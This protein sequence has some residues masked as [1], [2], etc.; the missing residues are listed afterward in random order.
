MSA[1]RR[2][3]VVLSFD[4]DGYAPWVSSPETCDPF[5]VSRG[6]FVP[7]A[8]RRLLCLL[9]EKDITATFFVPGHTVLTFPDVVAAAHAGGHEIGHHGWLHHPP[10]QR[11]PS[12]EADDLHRGLDAIMS[13]T[14]ER[15]ESYRA[16][17]FAP[18]L[19]TFRL[20]REFDF[21]CD[22]SLMGSDIDPYRLRVCDAWSGDAPYE[23]GPPSDIVELPVAN[24][25]D[26]FAQYEFLHSPSL[27]LPGLR[28]PSDVL[29]T[30][31]EDCRYLAEY[32]ESGVITITMHPEVTARTHR[33]LN[34]RRF[35]DAVRAKWGEQ[36]AFAS[37]KEVAR[38][39]AAAAPP[40]AQ[41]GGS[42]AG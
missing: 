2:K 13:V 7:E 34:L 3:F 37:I 5:N 31:L 1:W 38:D 17:H 33:L 39:W 16:P 19:T 27:T 14:A 23:Y 42:R 28:P 36:L 11:S 25:L 22:S 29:E 24:H 4:L 35:I 18:S 10:L 15:A 12:E 6:D 8:M 9:A 30:W 40:T 21:L 41:I 32:A 26:D 20:L